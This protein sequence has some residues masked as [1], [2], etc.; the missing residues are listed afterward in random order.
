MTSGIHGIPR[1][2]SE[3]HQY[4]RPIPVPGAAGTLQHLGSAWGRMLE[5]TEDFGLIFSPWVRWLD[6]FFGQ[7]FGCRHTACCLG[8]LG[9]QSH[10]LTPMDALQ[11]RP[12]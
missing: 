11:G 8:I 9:S 4:P 12:W 1:V 5:E 10:G 2:P 6:V 7:A 3:F